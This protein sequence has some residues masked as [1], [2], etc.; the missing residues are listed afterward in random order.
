MI[1]LFVM[2]LILEITIFLLKNM[3]VT[4]KRSSFSF[5]GMKC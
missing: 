3:I 4:L 2:L 1:Y 5:M